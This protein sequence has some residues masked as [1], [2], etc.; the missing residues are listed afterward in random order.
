VNSYAESAP[1]AFTTVE[2]E[3]IPAGWRAR[4][5]YEQLSADA[6]SERFELAPPG[7]ELALYSA[8]KLERVKS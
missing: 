3:N 7:K 6:W 1:L 5:T 8:S 4:E 2:I